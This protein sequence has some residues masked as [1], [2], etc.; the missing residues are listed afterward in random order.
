M[1]KSGGTAFRAGLHNGFDLMTES[2]TGVGNCGSLQAAAETF[3]GE[4]SMRTYITYPSS[5]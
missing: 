1:E 5:E 3:V 4:F 2:G